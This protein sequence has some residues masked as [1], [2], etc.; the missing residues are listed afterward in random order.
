MKKVLFPNLF[1]KEEM[2]SQLLNKY[3]IKYIYK[4]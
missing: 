3:I 1:L 2:T 4:I